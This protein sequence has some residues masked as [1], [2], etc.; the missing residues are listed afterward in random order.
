MDTCRLPHMAPVTSDLTSASGG[1]GAATTYF[2]GP[3]NLRSSNMTA[4]RGAK[5]SLFT[6]LCLG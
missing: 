4:G 1:T 6:N 3:N 2:L 5:P